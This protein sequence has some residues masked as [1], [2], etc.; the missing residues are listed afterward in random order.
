M[1]V[2]RLGFL[3]VGW[4]DLLDITVV[5]LLLYQIYNLVRGSVASRVFLGYL[6]VYLF[7]LVAKALGL[8]LLT[9]ILEYFIRV[10]WH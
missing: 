5:A 8:N 7:Y 1:L 2:F 3:D 6:L 4:L 10:R 9:T